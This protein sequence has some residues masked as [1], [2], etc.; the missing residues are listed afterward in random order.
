MQVEKK[1]A[2]HVHEITKDFSKRI[3]ATIFPLS[4]CRIIKWLLSRVEKIIRQSNLILNKVE[5]GREE[6][7]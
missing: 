7:K 6:E 1:F 3:S 5:D 4:P 2:N